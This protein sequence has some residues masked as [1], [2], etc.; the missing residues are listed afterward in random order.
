MS[1]NMQ[2]VGRVAFRQHGKLWVAYFAPNDTMDGAIKLGSIK[3]A[4]VQKP[5]RKKQFMDVMRDC[6]ADLIEEHV[7]ERPEF[8]NGPV[9]APG[10]ERLQ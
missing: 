10:H 3:L 2:Q 9:V 7:G 6:A 5:E 1:D 8:P 4:L